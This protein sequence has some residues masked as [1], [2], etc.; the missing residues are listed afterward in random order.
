MLKFTEENKEILRIIFEENSPEYNFLKAFEENTEFS[1]V[2]VKLQT[3]SMTNTR[4][5]PVT[6]AIKEYGDV[7]YRG[8]IALMTLFPESSM[9]QI[10]ED[11]ND[12]IDYKLGMLN[13]YHS[14]DKYSGGL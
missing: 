9:E 11:V 13:H 4:R 2:L 8:F 1:E 6:E 7:V 10:K 12:H 5:P 14:E 3:K